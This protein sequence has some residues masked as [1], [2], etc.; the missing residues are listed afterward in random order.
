M[1]TYSRSVRLS[2][3]ALPLLLFSLPATA[4]AQAGGIAGTVRDEASQS[5]LAAVLVDVVDGAGNVVASGATGTSGAFR[6]QD[7]PAGSYTVRFTSP[8]WNTNS[9]PGL[10]VTAGQLTSVTATMT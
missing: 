8:G 10:T 4:H 3:A 9:V 1:K 2:L 6:I 5:G 7:V